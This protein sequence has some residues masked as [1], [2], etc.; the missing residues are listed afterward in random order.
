VEVSIGSGEELARS[1]LLPR[2]T[3]MREGRGLSFQNDPFPQVRVIE[4][5][6]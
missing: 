1:F 4:R 5:R 3:E 2:V 6:Q